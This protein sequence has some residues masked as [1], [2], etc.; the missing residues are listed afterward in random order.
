MKEELLHTCMHKLPLSKVFVKRFDPNRPLTLKEFME[1]NP[2]LK[3]QT[4]GFIGPGKEEYYFFSK[5]SPLWKELKKFLLDSGFTSSDWMMLISDKKVNGRTDFSSLTKEQILSLPIGVLSP[6]SSTNNMVDVTVADF[7]KQEY[8]YYNKQV[9]A[10]QK[11]LISLG[12]TEN[13]GPFMSIVARDKNN[14]RLLRREK[15]INARQGI[16]ASMFM[17]FL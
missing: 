15:A 4:D 7:L 14:M 5:S 2:Y 6:G 17:Y 10:I 13:D 1:L 8:V 3:Y 12:F 9:G 11:I 16:Y